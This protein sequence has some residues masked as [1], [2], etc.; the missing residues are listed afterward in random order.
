MQALG[1]RAEA[2]RAIL[3][4]GVVDVRGRSG[5]G[6]AFGGLVTGGRLRL[7]EFD[8]TC[9]DS[10][11]GLAVRPGSGLGGRVV[12]TGRPAAV[13][14]Y[15][16]DRGIS[17]D[18]DAPVGKEGLRSVVAVPIVVESVVSGVLYGAVRE[19]QPIGDRATRLV[20][21]AADRVAKELSV[22]REV[23]RRVR[24]FQRTREAEH[25]RELEQIRNEERQRLLA[26]HA[27][28]QA[29][30]QRADGALQAELDAVSALL[31]EP[32]ERPAYEGG[33]VLLTAREFDALEAVASGCSNAE[34]AALMG[35]GLE[36][37]K[38]YLKSAYRKLGVR[39][40]L[41]AVVAARRL[42]LLP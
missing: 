34:A 24:S 35:V 2:E 31:V 10:L 13:H 18:Y 37:V 11:R 20:M 36:T 26:V 9:T 22:R 28:L 6:V 32:S 15:A 3:W 23:E 30:A 40:R 21:A 29:L 19:P 5:V 14:D 39:S 41:E 4:R 17:H 16:F 38:T 42:G 12:A 1:D 7:S 27:R 25:R 33:G 8:G